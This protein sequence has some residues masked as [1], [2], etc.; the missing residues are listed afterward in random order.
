MYGTP[1]KGKI[2][3]LKILTGPVAE[4]EKYR[5]LRRCGTDR[6]NAIIFPWI[7]DVFKWQWSSYKYLKIF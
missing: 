1:G 6:K 3:R 2:Q 5:N 7:L 4:R